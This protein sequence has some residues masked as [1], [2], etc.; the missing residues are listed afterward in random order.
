[1]IECLKFHPEGFYMM[2]SLS[3]GNSCYFETEEEI[4]IFQ[5]MI[6]RYLG[7]Y[8]KIHSLYISNEGY[9]LLVQIR[10]QSVLRI[11]YA[12]K[13]NKGGKEI[14]PLFYSEP[15]RIVSEQVRILHSILVKTVNKIR[16][17]KGVLVQRRYMRYYFE[18]K[19]SFEGYITE[20]EKGKEISGQENKKYRVKPSWKLGI[21]WGI[22]RA[23]GWV[24]GMSSIDLTNDVVLTLIKQTFLLQNSPPPT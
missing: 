19:E 17:R 3:S 10:S 18:S 14:N 20:M 1:M 7:A 11:I 16:G 2:E 15:W 13:C 4:N 6:P 8:L 5:K 12:K 21:R 9:H 23:K 24:L 22:F